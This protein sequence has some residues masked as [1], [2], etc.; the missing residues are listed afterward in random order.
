MM[1][2]LRVLSVVV[3]VLPFCAWATT[4]GELRLIPPQEKQ[5]FR[6]IIHPLQQHIPLVHPLDN[7]DGVAYKV[8]DS[9]FNAFSYYGSNQTCVMWDP[10]TNAFITIKRGALVSRPDNPSP[11]KSNNIF[12]VW[13]TDNGQ[14]WQRVGPVV[15]GN[16]SD[17]YPRYPAIALIRSDVSINTL[18]NSI[19]NFYCP[20]TD[21]SSWAGMVAGYHINAPGSA[22]T[23]VVLRNHIDQSTGYRYTFGTTYSTASITRDAENAFGFALS[24]LSVSDA[25]APYR[26]NNNNAI[27]KTDLSA[28]A[29][30]VFTSEIPPPLRA[31]NFVDPQQANSRTNTE[32]AFDLDSE[33]NLYAGVFGLFAAAE[34][35][36]LL[37][38]GVTK[39]SD[40]GK[41][42]SDW[43]ILPTSIIEAYV[44]ANGGDPTQSGFR[45]SWGWLGDA[46]GNT[47]VTS[48][49]DFVVTG[50]DEYS[51]AAQLVLI[52]GQSIVG[53]HYVEV[54]YERGQW[55]IRKIADAS[56]FET[57][58]QMRFN[59]GDNYGPSQLGC[60]LQLARTADYN[61][62]L[63]KTLEARFIVWGGDTL[64]TT[65]VVVSVRPK[66]GSTWE[67]LRNV[68]RSRILDRITWIPKVIPSTAENIPLLTVQS[69]YRGSS[70]REYYWDNQ[71]LLAAASQDPSPEEILRYRQYVTY[72][73]FN[74]EDLPEW[75]PATSVEKQSNNAADIMLLPNPASNDV[76]F[77]RSIASMDATIEIVNSLGQVVYR[78]V[79][80]AGVSYHT[81]DVTAMAP[82]VYHCRLLYGPTVKVEPLSIVR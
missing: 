57:S 36:S 42:W 38:F 76:T 77:Y 81:F 58:E 8:F 44:A 53:V 75:N 78:A 40:N 45:F 49:K 13:T 79:I 33:D 51:F 29:V 16:P 59:N 35:T 39:S 61:V 72:S 4:N 37:T 69:A 55:G 2:S 7:T 62:L 11:D 18:D 50:K 10:Q 27:I 82:G 65:D 6:E 26:E 31:E 25:S 22:P 64:L 24:G 63:F 32:V 15:V 80:P 30:E 20:L 21:G 67:P 1:R 54:Y 52:S 19:F 5:F 23:T 3:F 43:N 12:I 56:L 74:Y 66:N 47:R 71:F 60:E 70:D 41:T 48:A 9:L 14:S 68:T 17:G 73:T 34:N 28:T 46:S